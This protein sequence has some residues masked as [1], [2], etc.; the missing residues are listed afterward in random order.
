M[1]KEGRIVDRGSPQELIN[2]YGRTNLEEVFLA[3]CRLG[4]A[5]DL[6]L[7]RHANSAVHWGLRGAIT[8]LPLWCST[9]SMW[10]W[11]PPSFFIAF[12]NARRRGALLQ[13][14]E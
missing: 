10:G 4:A 1:M 7:R 12:H 2:R 5:V 6:C 13:M 9:R 8:S 3:A 14:G 11:A